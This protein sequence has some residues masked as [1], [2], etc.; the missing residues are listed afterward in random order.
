MHLLKAFG[1]VFLKPGETKKVVMSLDERSFAFYNINIPGW[2]VEA[3]DYEI[4]IGASSRDLRLKKKISV[5]SN[6]DAEIP[7]Y[8]DTAS[9]YYNLDSG[10]F[11]ISDKQFIA[12]YGKKLPQ[13]DIEPGELIHV[14]SM[15]KDTTH[16]LAGRL[17]LKLMKQQVG[18]MLSESDGDDAESGRLMMEAVIKEMPIRAIGML[19]GD[20]LPKYFTEG[21]ILMLNGSFFKGLSLMLKKK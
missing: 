21:F 4:L 17:M 8:K 2:H 20:T 7:D 1:K 18:K 10:K 6:S 12:V 14:N 11:E 5:D 15:L 3:G 19:G 16:K 13:R 9:G